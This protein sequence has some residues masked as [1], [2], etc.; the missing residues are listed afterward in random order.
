MSFQVQLGVIIAL[1]FQASRRAKCNELVF[2]FIK[3]NSARSSV[4]AEVSALGPSQKAFFEEK[5]LLDPKMRQD[6][7]TAEVD[8]INY[9]ILFSLPESK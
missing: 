5:F 9:D 4:S 7:G 1:A 6:C 8:S 2:A 3:S